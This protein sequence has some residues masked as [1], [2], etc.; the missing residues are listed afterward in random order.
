MQSKNFT[1]ESGSGVLPESLES[2]YFFYG[3]PITQ[4]MLPSNLKKLELVGF[5][6]AIEPGLFPN[7][8]EYLHVGKITAPLQRGCLPSNLK[9]FQVHSYKFEFQKGI[10]PPC[11]EELSLEKYYKSFKANVLPQ[12]LTSLILLNFSGSFSSVGPVNKLSTLIVNGLHLSVSTLLQNVKDIYIEL[13]FLS[14]DTTLY[15][16]VIESLKINSTKADGLPIKFLPPSLRHLRLY[17]VHINS[18][19]VINDGCVSVKSDTNINDS[20]IPPSVI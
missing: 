18:A 14:D 7:S 6:Q 19:G 15:N 4:C 3:Y 9:R 8:L 12:S 11:L 13:N 2:L 20:F 17:N 5:K 16:T 10:L 1:I